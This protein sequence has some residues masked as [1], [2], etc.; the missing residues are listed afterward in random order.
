MAKIGDAGTMATWPQ[1]GRAIAI[2]IHYWPIFGHLKQFWPIL[3]HYLPQGGILSLRLFS[4]PI[5]MIL[6]LDGVAPM[7]TDPPPISSTTL[8]EKKI[9]KKMTHDT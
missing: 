3:G 7:M 1:G 8:S 9:N 5:P 6:K 4:E 2:F